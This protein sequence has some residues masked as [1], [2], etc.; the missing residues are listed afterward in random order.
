MFVV[1]SLLVLWG[2]DCGKFSPFE[3]IILIVLSLFIVAAMK[4]DR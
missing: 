3:G 2:M 1:L 4:G